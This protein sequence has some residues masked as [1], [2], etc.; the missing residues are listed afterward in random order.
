MRELE[1]N[2]RPSTLKP[3]QCTVL[4]LCKMQ[5]PIEKNLI[6]FL[7]VL[8]SCSFTKQGSLQSLGSLPASGA[9]GFRGLGSLPFSEEP[10]RIRQKSLGSLPKTEWP[11]EWAFIKNDLKSVKSTVFGRMAPKEWDFG[12]YQLYRFQKMPKRIRPNNLVKPG[13]SK[14]CWKSSK[15]QGIDFISTRQ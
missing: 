3:L 6:L 13:R 2:A 11:K 5:I 10:K 14:T 4:L 8:Q 7:N 12:S 15:K 9:E 1:Y